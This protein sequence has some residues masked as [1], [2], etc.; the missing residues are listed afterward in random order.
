MRHL[1]FLSVTLSKKVSGVVEVDGQ[2]GGMVASKKSS[3]L[4]GLRCT[5]W[6][7]G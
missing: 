6:I 5:F 4:D 3:G 1:S 2:M 7:S